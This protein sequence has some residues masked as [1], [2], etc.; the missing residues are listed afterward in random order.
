VTEKLYFKTIYNQVN[1]FKQAYGDAIV[2]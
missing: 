1:N 2:K